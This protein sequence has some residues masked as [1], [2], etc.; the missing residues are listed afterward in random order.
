[1]FVIGYEVDLRLIRGAGRVAASVSISS[2][3]L[4]LDLAPRSA[5]GWRTGIT[6]A[7]SRRSCCSSH[8]DGGHGL[9]GSW[10]ASWRPRPAPHAHRRT[11]AGQRGCRRRARLVT[12]RGRGR[13]GR[14]RGHELR[15]ALAPAYLVVIFGVFRPLLRKLAQVYERQ[16]RLTP[17]SWPR[18]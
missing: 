9:P 10:P 1:M 8:R 12:P 17:P 11:R 6:C 18:C 14:D 5:S 16:G 4:P 3:I 15:L 7:T 13:P 2:V